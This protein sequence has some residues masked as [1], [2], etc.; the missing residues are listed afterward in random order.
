MQITSLIQRNVVTADPGDDLSAAARQM[1]EKHVGYLVVTE[2]DAER[3]G[4][5]PVGVVTD[6]DLVISVIAAD[7]DPRALR[8]G[9]VMSRNPVTLPDTASFGMAL[10]EMRRIGVRRLPVINGKGQLEGIVSL[11]DI[12]DLLAREL[13]DVAGSI[14]N[15]RRIESAT[16]S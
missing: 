1:R 3:G 15:A 2:L 9:D 4:Q 14:S 7:A 12:I 10:R 8:V 11:D 16:R 5:R 6:R 13:G